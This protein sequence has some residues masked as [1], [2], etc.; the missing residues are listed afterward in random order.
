MSANPTT[1]RPSLAPLFFELGPDECIA[2]LARNEIGRLA[3]AFRAR[4]DVQPIDYVYE[5]GRLFGRTSLGEKLVTLRHSP[6]VAFEV[7]EVAGAFDWRSVVVHGTF[8]LLAEDGSPTERRTRRHA[9]EL[10]RHIVPATGTPG[11]PVPFRDVVFEVVVDTISGRQAT[12]M[13]G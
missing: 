4:I 8:Y 11:D 2:I 1:T 3:F 7:D 10:L 13:P 5:D 12:T 9:M 6:W